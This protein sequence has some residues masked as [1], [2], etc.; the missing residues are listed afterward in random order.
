MAKQG[1]TRSL[2]ALALGAGLAWVARDIPRQMGAKAKGG[3]L[4]RV[5]RSPQFADGKFRNTVPATMITASSMPKVLGK[6]LTDRARRHP[7]Q[8]IPVVTPN[9]QP[10]RGGKQNDTPNPQPTRGG[11]QND[12]PNAGDPDGLYVTWYGHS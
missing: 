9:T 10:T 11:K 7:H 2:A 1:R 3:R 6:A 12:T 5:G 8:P 4:E